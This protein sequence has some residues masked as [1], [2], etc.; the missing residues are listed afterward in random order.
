LALGVNTDGHKELLGMWIAKSATG[1]QAETALEVFGQK[2]DEKYPTISQMWRRHRENVIPF[3][4]YPADI[5]KAIYTTNAI[6]S[7]NRSLR[8]VIKTKGAFPTDASIMKIFYLALENISKKWTMPVRCWKSAM[9]QF[10]IKFAYRM[11]L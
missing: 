10:A 3:F 5:R 1:Q 2:W 7:I 11:P 8:K 6:E 9:N 4:D